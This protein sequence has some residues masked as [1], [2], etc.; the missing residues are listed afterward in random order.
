LF[1]RLLQEG[2]YSKKS[3][4]DGKFLPLLSR[5]RHN[6]WQ[7]WQPDT[8]TDDRRE[9]IYRGHGHETPAEWLKSEKQRASC[10]LARWH[11][12]DYYVELWFE[13]GAMVN[14]FKHYT[15][16]ITLR[17]FYGMASIPYKW[18]MAK[19]LERCAAIY[20]KPIIVLYFGD[21]DPGG[22]II[23]ETSVND[24]RKWCDARFEFIR[25]GLNPGD[26]IKYSIQEIPGKPGAYQWEALND[27]DARELI[28]S[29]VD[30]YVDYSAMDAVGEIES[31]A[32]RNLR[33]H[34]AKLTL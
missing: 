1:Y 17:P 5:A 28:T 7:S 22:Q 18:D 4:Y 6:G 20:G 21:N 2:F 32:T 9:A 33:R 19:S 11:T 13:A 34:I 29:S 27:D 30:R 14:Q 3:D 24:V 15:R 25:V 31:Q 12:Q 26:E 8:L 10:N 16:N 23:P